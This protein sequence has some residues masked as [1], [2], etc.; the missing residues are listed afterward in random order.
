MHI[1]SFTTN[2]N[3][4]FKS[5]KEKAITKTIAHSTKH[6]INIPKKEIKHCIKTGALI[7]EIAEFFQCSYSTI[8]KLIQEYKLEKMYQNV[9]S[10]KPPKGL[11]FPEEEFIKLIKE[12]KSIK[13]LAEYY[14]CSKEP[15]AKAIKNF[16]LTELYDTAQKKLYTI[17]TKNDLIELVSKGY[18]IK[19]LAAHYGCNTNTISIFLKKFDLTPEYKRIQ[20]SKEKDKINLPQE[21]LTSMVQ[22]GCLTKDISQKFGCSITT[23]R[24]HLLKYNLMDQ[25]R[26]IHN[27]VNHTVKNIPFEKL[28]ELVMAGKKIDEIA[29]IFNCSKTPIFRIMNKHNLLDFYK[30]MHNS[31][32]T[33]KIKISQS[34][35]TKLIEE[36]KSIEEL[37]QIFSCSSGTIR[38][39]LKRYKLIDKY[40]SI[41]H[42]QNY[43]I[44]I[45]EEVLNA[46]IENK[47]N[48]EEMSQIH[49][50][51]PSTIK[52]Q[53]NKYKL[54]D[55]YKTIHGIKTRS[56]PILTKDIKQMLISGKTPKEIAKIYNCNPERIRKI[57]R[58]H[59]LKVRKKENS[60][61]KI[62]PELYTALINEGYTIHS[63]QKIFQC[64]LNTVVKAL[65]NYNLMKRYLEIQNSK[66]K[67]QKIV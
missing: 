42:A 60:P 1:F 26:T 16:K 45:S 37:T 65:K 34:K 2:Y 29:E 3:S 40:K 53:L 25:Y 12:G 22:T 27:S 50:C 63:M 61:I 24:K 48:I 64:D 36:G 46:N 4:N 55:K 66:T 33:S 52:R 41:H 56:I 20:A 54:T 23:V 62:T 43:H 18:S 19:Q 30:K 11:K 67:N 47:L 59:K 38:N 8:Y 39:A 58:K 13:E 17:I 15:I 44:N 32:N 14:N 10:A 57:I 5:S 51:S 21:D 31:I 9:Q 6:R 7:N 35:I 49:N 28:K